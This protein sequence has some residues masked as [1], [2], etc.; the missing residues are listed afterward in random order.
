MFG[1][2][3]MISDVSSK[4][5]QMCASFQDVLDGFMNTFR[6]DV[7]K[8]A[9]GQAS[10]VLPA[11]PPDFL[12]DLFRLA[13]DTFAAEPS[14]LT[15]SFPCV[16]VGD[17]HGQILDLYRILET[18]G[19]PPRRRYLFLGDIVDR[20]EFSLETLVIVYLLKVIWPED[21]YL[22]RGNHEFTFLCSQCGFMSQTFE[23]YSDFSIYSAAI[24][25]F[26]YIPLAAVIGGSFLCVHGGL[27]PDVTDLDQIR[28]IL[29][30]IEEFGNS[31]VDSLVWSD[32]SDTV[33]TFAPSPSRGTGYI[34]GDRAV[35]DLLG[36]SGLQM[37]IRAHEFVNSG[38]QTYFNG[39]TMTV[40]SASNYCG[41]IGNQ[42]AVLDIDGG[43]LWAVRQ[44]APLPWLF[45]KNVTFR[46]LGKPN[47]RYRQPRLELAQS[48]LRL[49]MGSSKATSAKIGFGGP[50]TASLTHIELGSWLDDD[51]TDMAKSEPVDLTRRRK[52]KPAVFKP[53]R[54]ERLSFG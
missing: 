12:L 44:F 13:Q 30:P 33:D 4:S 35:S 25:S 29:R 26:N 46:P 38:F 39:S 50:A 27:G 11:L 47:F 37:L 31:L 49:K 17:I 51:D 48:L 40:F 24:S 45:R 15:V 20:G 6:E 3:A 10:L 54:G 5:S 21:V 16:V 42:G 34:F 18:F 1:P 32:P 19:L 7:D 14:L 23:I 53:K 9:T 22:I 36:Q 28:N 52:E 8:Y 2:P 43:G 41:L